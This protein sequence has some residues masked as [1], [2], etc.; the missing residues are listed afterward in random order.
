PIQPIPHSAASALVFVVYFPASILPL[1]SLPRLNRK[2]ERGQFAGP[3]APGLRGLPSHPP[4]KKPSRTKR[5]FA[6]PGC[7]ARCAGMDGDRR[8]ASS[9]LPAA[10]TF[11]ITPS[12]T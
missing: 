5:I 11:G 7:P 6:L 8:I 2:R 3:L 1:R 4:F 10:L 12:A 9:I